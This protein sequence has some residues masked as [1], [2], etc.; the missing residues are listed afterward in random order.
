MHIKT[1]RI[2]LSMRVTP[3]IIVPVLK[4]MCRTL[5][6]PVAGSAGR[7][8]GGERFFVGLLRVTSYGSRVE[9]EFRALSP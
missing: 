3:Q 9:L 7:A 8:F 4:F 2:A 1:G 6:C 5:Q